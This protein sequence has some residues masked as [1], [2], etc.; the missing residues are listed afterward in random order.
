VVAGL[1]GSPQKRSYTVIGDAVNTASRLETLTKHL[2]ASILI[3]GE[4][5]QRLSNSDRFLLR[6]LGSYRLKGKDTPVVIADVMGEDDGSSF[7]R[8]LKEEIARV[9]EALKCLQARDFVAASVGFTALVAYVGNA[10]RALGYRFLADTARAYSAR[11]P[12]SW[13]GVIDM[14]DK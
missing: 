14:L 9:G 2:G 4:V 11:P 13:D 10:T 5:S 8:P 7:V 6:P 3:S 1:I 12:D